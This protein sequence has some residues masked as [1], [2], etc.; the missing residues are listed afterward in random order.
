MTD[1]ASLLVRLR[2]KKKCDGSEGVRLRVSLFLFVL[3][4]KITTAWRVSLDSLVA[5]CFALVEL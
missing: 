5:P 1:N 4:Q 2:D 3:A